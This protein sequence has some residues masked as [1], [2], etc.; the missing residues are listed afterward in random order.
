MVH[1]FMIEWLRYIVGVNLILQKGFT[2][3]VV[4]QMVS[5]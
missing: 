4:F 5:D 3:L 2:I 1:K